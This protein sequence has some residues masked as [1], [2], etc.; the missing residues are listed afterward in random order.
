MAWADLEIFYNNLQLCN[1]SCI[2]IK[3]RLEITTEASIPGIDQITRQ[4]LL[5]IIVK[6]CICFFPRV[7]ETLES[8]LGSYVV[9]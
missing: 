2:L 7:N 1:L 8:T 6:V 3:V 9:S 5:K 4:A